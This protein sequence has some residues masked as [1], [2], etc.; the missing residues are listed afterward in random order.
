MSSKQLA[1]VKDD[2]RHIKIV[3]SAEPDKPGK[4]EIRSHLLELGWR[5]QRLYSGDYMF[6]TYQYHKLGITRKTTFDML[7]SINKTFAQQLEEMLETY[8]ICVLLI[9]NPW[10]WT[11]D[12][13]QLLTARGLERHVKKEVLNYIHRWEAK[14][15]ILERTVNWQDTVDRLNELYA[16][17]QKPY[18][19]SAR[20]KGYVDER[21]LA[22]PSGLR[23]QAGERLL[24]SRSL[25][26]IANM[27]AEQVLKARI[28]GIG[29][30]RATLVEQHFTRR[31]DNADRH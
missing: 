26:D 15:F 4:A 31:T 28:E 29:K 22:L 30:K 8:D 5:Q 14:G 2:L 3:D 18:S 17:Y 13:G 25:R 1:L 27:S 20:S 10:K 21:L 11:S 19:L 6:F 16:L 7:T 9:E 24:N 12:T 23:G